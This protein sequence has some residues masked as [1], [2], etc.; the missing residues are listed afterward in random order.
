MLTLLLHQ[1]GVGLNMPF[2][3]LKRYQ[4]ILLIDF[5]IVLLFLYLTS[6][7]VHGKLKRSQIKNAFNTTTEHHGLA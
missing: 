3:V 7:Q 6:H 4:V 2:L 5:K 1:A